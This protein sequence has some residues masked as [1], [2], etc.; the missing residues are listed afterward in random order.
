MKRL[1]PTLL[2]ESRE[3][4]WSLVLTWARSY[5]RDG[6]GLAADVQDMQPVGVCH[7]GFA[8][9]GL[10]TGVREQVNIAAKQRAEKLRSFT[11]IDQSSL[12]LPS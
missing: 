12:S 11:L 1:S 4:T 2:P 5:G 10:W 3:G 9:S 8:L 7:P 6:P